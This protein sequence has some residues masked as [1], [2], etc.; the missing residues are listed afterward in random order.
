M[1][2]DEVKTRLIAYEASLEMIKGRFVRGRDSLTIAQDDQARLHQ[3]VIE[4]ADLV[5]DELEEN[6]Y[7]I[8]LIG[9]FNEGVQNFYNSSSYSSVERLLSTVRAIVTRI[10]MNPRL[11]KGT[12]M[13]RPTI[14]PVDP[15]VAERS[16]KGSSIC[17]VRRK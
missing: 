10:E 3:I 6:S 5:E 7:R 4:M 9:A 2:P 11:V 16:S 8:M 13:P 15:A 14:A 1:T 12:A 17:G